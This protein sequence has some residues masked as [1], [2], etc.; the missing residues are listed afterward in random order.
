MKAGWSGNGHCTQ[1]PSVAAIWTFAGLRNVD[2]G[3][4]SELDL[5][6]GQSLIKTNSFLLSARDRSL[7]SG[8]QYR[9]E[10]NHSCYLVDRKIQP[11]F[12]DSNDQR[13]SCI[14]RLQNALLAFQLLKPLQTS[15]F[16]FQ[17]RE[18]AN[19]TL[20]LEKTTLR[21]PMEAGTWARMRRFDREFLDRVP[22]FI[23]K[24]KRVM[25]GTEV[26]KKNALFLLQLALENP[27]PLISGLL[28]VMGMEAILDSSDRYEFRTKICS[29]VGSSTSV[30]PDWNSAVFPPPPKTVDMVAI[31]LYM[32]RSK[33]AHGAGL[34]KAAIDKKTPVDLLQKVSLASDLEP[35]TYAIFLAEAAIYLL[36]Q[37]LQTIL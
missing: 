13:Q 36:C 30:F 28:A 8:L 29:L 6:Y 26:E 32:L 37:V 4:Q 19:A 1:D 23:Q 33:L 15:G 18:G 5:G 7:M 16:I 3:G 35:T 2:L 22:G 31:D 9:D 25:E 12:P 20:H 14:E 10:E 27:H 11:I 21:L 24:V 17:G 34:R